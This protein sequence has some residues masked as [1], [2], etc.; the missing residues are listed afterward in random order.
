MKFLVT[1]AAGFI[2]FHVSQRLLAAG[3][4]VVGIDNL[5]DYYDVSLKQARLDQIAQHPEF[6]FVKM[7]L[8]DRQ[9]ISSLFSNHG[10]DRVIH[11]GAQAGVR[12]SIENPHA[13]ADANLIGHLNILEGC[14]HHKIGHLLYASSSSVYGLNRKMPFSTDDSVDHPISLYAATKKANELMSHS[15]SHLYQLPTT[16]LRF[17]TVYGPWGR[18]DM[19]LFKFTRAMLA[20]EQID[21]YNRG[22]MT[23]DFTY[24]DDIAE[25]IVRLQDVIPQADENWTVEAG[26]PAASSAPYRVYN[27]GNSQPTSL[28]TYIESLEKALG[29][30]ANKNML[31]MQPGDVPGTSAD[32]QPLFEAI[33]FRPQTGV[34]EGVQNFVDWYRRFYQQ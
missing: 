29:I 25:S 13:Y 4:Q 32:T 22:Q 14:R 20:G 15:Y 16:G 2:G 1:G 34:E 9:A 31:P 26:S 7:D 5:N 8:A 6:I 17:F 3:H 33:D 30:E 19:A 12:Y 28:M 18:P 21:V 27:I 24:I 23:R 10:F 11:L